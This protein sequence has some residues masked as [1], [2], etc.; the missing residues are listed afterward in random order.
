MHRYGSEARHRGG[1][2]RGPPRDRRRRATHALRRLRHCYVRLPGLAAG[3]RGLPPDLDT[4]SSASLRAPWRA[5][6][7]GATPSKGVDSRDGP[8]RVALTPRPRPPPAIPPETSM[9]PPLW[10]LPVLLGL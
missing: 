6:T 8:H 10:L 9:R 4:N 5:S 1:G 7:I 2:W 3:S